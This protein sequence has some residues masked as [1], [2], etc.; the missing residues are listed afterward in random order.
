MTQVLN[1]WRQKDG[2]QTDPIYRMRKDHPATYSNVISQKNLYLY[3]VYFFHI[4]VK[5]MF[6]RAIYSKGKQCL[7]LSMTE[8]K[9]NELLGPLSGMK[10]LFLG[11]S[12]GVGVPLESFEDLE[13][14]S[15]AVGVSHFTSLESLR[16]LAGSFRGS[17]T[18]R[19][20]AHCD[21]FVIKKTAAVDLSSC[22]CAVLNRYSN[23]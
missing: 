20:S 17:D 4:I 21:K 8:S 10:I 15:F 12:L 14:G 16:S 3:V 23:I 5:R 7:T 1:R 13:D 19:L 11:I 2:A 6:C 22:R 9:S 18:T